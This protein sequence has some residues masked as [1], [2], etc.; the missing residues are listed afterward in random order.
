MDID[1]LQQF[2]KDLLT[3]AQKNDREVMAAAALIT[4]GMVELAKAFE[5]NQ[6][7]IVE[8]ELATKKLMGEI[9]EGLETLAEAISSRTSET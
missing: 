6:H 5:R 7:E 4:L 9:H 8:R 1:E 3:E 2:S